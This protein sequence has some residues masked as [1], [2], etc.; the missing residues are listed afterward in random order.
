MLAL[1]YF[2]VVWFLSGLVTGI[3]SFGSN[4]FAVPLI[5]LVWEPR[6]A[7]LVGCLSAFSIFF[8]L[9]V[10][11]RSKILWK[12]TLL[13][14]L[15]SLGGIPLGIWFLGQAGSRALLLAAGAS[16][17][18]FLLWQCL[19]RIFGA[20]QKKIGFAWVLPLGFL[21]GILMGSIG[22]GGPPLVLYTFLRQFSKEETLATINAA[23]VAIMLFV[24]PGQYLSGLFDPETIKL[25]A[26]GGVAA[27]IGILASIPLARHIN[28]GLFRKLLL[29]MLALSMATLFLRALI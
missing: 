4:L 9:A 28:I 11:Y 15:G 16:L 6:Q 2:N 12:D 20:Q 14:S 21:S 25:G 18:I 13:L 27:F 23:S 29:A 26:I 24:L 1:V 10:V 17:A 7:I 19:L 5:A 22:M 8:E 3:T